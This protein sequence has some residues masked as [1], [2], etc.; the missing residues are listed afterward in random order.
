MIRHGAKLLHAFAEAVVPKVTVV[1]R[2]AYGGALITMNSKDLGA[3]LVLRLAGRRDRDHGRRSRPSGS[4]TGARSPRPTTPR[5]ER[6]R[7]ADEYADEHLSAAAAAREGFIDELVEP[8]ETRRRLAG[9]LAALSGAGELR[10]RRREHPAVTIVRG[11]RRQLH[12]GSRARAAAL[13][14]RAGARS[15]GRTSL[16]EPGLGGRDQRGR[17]AGAARAGARA[18]ARPRHARV[19]GQRRPV[20]HEPDPDAYAARLVAHVRAAA[21]R[22]AAGAR[23][24]PPPIPTSGASSTCGRARA[25]GWRRGWSCFN[26]ACRKVARRHDV[27]LLDGFDHPAATSAR[28]T[29]TTASTPPPRATAR[30]R[31]S[32]CARSESV[33]TNRSVT[34]STL[35][36]REARDTAPGPDLLARPSTSFRWATG[37]PPRGR[38]SRARPTSSASPP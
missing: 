13:A 20:Q 3:D 7:L 22:A 35:A 15:S 25:R 24:S 28:P 31:A 36:E 5:R 34:R 14:G 21:A 16:R 6:D 26:A 8:Q 11:P 37:S 33:P 38:T 17:R 1:L 18:R 27:A 2:K 10:Q 23:S 30:P 29:P 32:S 12:R 9:A 4:S 19:R